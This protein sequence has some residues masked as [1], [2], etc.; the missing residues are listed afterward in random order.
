MFEAVL[1]DTAAHMVQCYLDADVC[2][3]WHERYL[4]DAA[5]VTVHMLALTA[6]LYLKSALL[7]RSLTAMQAQVFVFVS[8]QGCMVAKLPPAHGKV[9]AGGAD[10]CTVVTAAV[11][12]QSARVISDLCRRLVARAAALESGSACKVGN[13]DPDT[14]SD[15]SDAQNAWAW[16]SEDV[17]EASEALQL[18][19]DVVPGIPSSTHLSHAAPA[20]PAAAVVRALAADGRALGAGAAQLDKGAAQGGKSLLCTL[21]GPAALSAQQREVAA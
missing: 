15:K 16:V 19:L 10:A 13:S 21:P 1:V 5:F 7:S 18:H 9:C 2:T 14:A 3:A 6:P 12:A 8:Q 11:S 17:Q 20:P 4:T